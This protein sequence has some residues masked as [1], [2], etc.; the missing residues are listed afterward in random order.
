LAGVALSVC[1]LLALAAGSAVGAA[2]PPD[3]TGTWTPTTGGAWL[4]TASGT[5][6]THLHVEW[7]GTGSHA[8]LR[9]TFDG[10]LNGTGSGYAGSFAVAE[11]STQVSGTMTVAIDSSSEVTVTLTPTNG[12]GSTIVMNRSG[13][14]SPPP[15]TPPPAS[16]PGFDVP[17][18]LPLA[19]GGL[20]TVNSPALPPATKELDVETEVSDAEVAKFAA[21]LKLVLDAYNRA[22]QRETYDLVCVA[23]ASHPVQYFEVSG[24][25]ACAAILP[26]LFPGSGLHGLRVLGSVGA[27]RASFVPLSKNSHPL[28]P[29]RARNTIALARSLVQTSCSLSGSKLSFHVATRGSATLNALLGTRAHV[30]LRAL[31]KPSGSPRLSVTWHRASPTGPSVTF[32]QNG[33]PLGQPLAA[34]AAAND[35]EANMDPRTGVVANAYWTQG[36]HSLGPIAVPAGATGLAFSTASGSSPGTPLARPKAATGFHVFWNPS[37]V[38]ISASWTSVGKLL[39]TIPVSSGQK[40][41]A[42]TNG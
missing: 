18:T 11:G 25:D 38:I 42:F 5:G 8:D 17:L 19:L 20:V 41:I 12:N 29:Q 1:A 3:L 15:A 22:R 4:F 32:T 23:Y 16:I 6:L 39:A 13:G 28:N 30:D 24:T 7:A 27:C 31:G 36:G 33:S 14:A 37:G 40:A 2:Q 9:G 35:V 26:K 34:P 21:T 10:T